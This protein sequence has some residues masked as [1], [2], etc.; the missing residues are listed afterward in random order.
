MVVPKGLLIIFILFVGGFVFALRA[1]IRQ[2]RKQGKFNRAAVN[3]TNEVG[4]SGFS[5]YQNAT[6][7]KQVT[8]LV[9]DG[10]L[11]D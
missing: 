1:I 6:D 10:R 9:V 4:E 8:Y 5:S 7:K 11:I 2:E 3:R